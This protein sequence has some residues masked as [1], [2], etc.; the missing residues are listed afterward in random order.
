MLY[1]LIILADVIWEKDWLQG[2][3]IL[4]ETLICYFC[5]M[6]NILKTFLPKDFLIKNERF[7]RKIIY[8]YHI[9]NSYQCSICEKKFRKFLLNQRGEKLCPSCGSMPRDRRLFTEFKKEYTGHDI[10]KLLDFSPSRSLYRRLKKS[11]NIRYFPTDLSTDFI[12]EYQYDITKIP[13]EDDFFDCIFCYHILEHI[14]DDAKAMSEL[15]RVLKKGG[16]IFVQTPFKEGDIYEVPDARTDEDRLKYFGQAD[17]VRL[18]SVNGLAERLEKA[19]FTVEIKTFDLD[20]NLGSSKKDT[21]L[22][23][24]KN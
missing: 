14:E 2:H 6:Y 15:Y 17:H 7:F 5:L 8:L 13:V 18:Y 3:K 12:A 22:L 16:K 11:R 20:E 9:G 23:L 24:S 4:T 1:E 21:V 10:I 19:G